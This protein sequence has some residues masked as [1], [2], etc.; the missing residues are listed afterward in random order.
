MINR[1][2]DTHNE[3]GRAH[4]QGRLGKGRQNGAGADPDK[5]DGHHAPPAPD[6]G[7]PSGRQTAD[8]EGDKAR[9]RVRNKLGIGHIPLAS[10][11]QSR[12]GRE[13]E[14]EE[15]IE[16]MSDI[17]KE[18]MQLVTCKKSSPGQLNDRRAAKGP[19]TAGSALHCFMETN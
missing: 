13:N 11:N 15:M 14:Y 1:G 2:E 5:E 4:L 6:I 3:K 18:E 16:Q 8:A 7:N 17:Q 19:Q 9:R 12:D 10:E